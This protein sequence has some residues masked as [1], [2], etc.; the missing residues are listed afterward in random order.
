MNWRALPHVFR[1]LAAA[2]E[3]V[4]IWSGRDDGFAY[5]VRERVV[6]PNRPGMRACYT[7]R[8]PFSVWRRPL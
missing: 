7:R 4:A 5:E 3:M 1:T 6:I 2:S 8:P